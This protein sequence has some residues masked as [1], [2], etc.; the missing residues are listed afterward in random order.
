MPSPDDRIRWWTPIIIAPIAVLLGVIFGAMT[1]VVNA[2]VSLDYFSIVMDWEASPQVLWHWTILQ[3][4]L[5]GGVLG[6]IFGIIFSITIAASTRL[7]CP[8]VFAAK[9]LVKAVLVVLVCWIIGG[10]IGVTLSHSNRS[11]WGS[12]FIA[13]PPTLSLP[14]F[15]WV[16][17]TINGAYLGVPI[18]L[19][20]LSILF[21]WRWR[22]SAPYAMPRGFP[23]IE[24][25]QG[26]H[27]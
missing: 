4:V 24:V 11:L 18:A 16:G 27:P 7:R 19:L 22:K 9:Y 12:V 3:G 23:V 8:L 20:W 14:R 13:V 2:C 25:R 6:S 15:A 21:H 26:D 1:N 17:G 10:V 5:E